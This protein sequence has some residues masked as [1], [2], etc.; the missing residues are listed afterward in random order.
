MNAPKLSS[1]I[2]QTK[3]VDLNTTLD[4]DAVAELEK[5]LS[6]HMADEIDK[7]IIKDIFVRGEREKR[8]ADRKQRK[9]NGKL[10][11]ILL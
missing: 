5:L 9:R 10:R 7:Q 6:Y 2:I 3:I 4:I 11:K 8:K 1:K